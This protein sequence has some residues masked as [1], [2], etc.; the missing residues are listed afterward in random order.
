METL[1]SLSVEDFRCSTCKFSIP[2]ISLKEITLE[3]K[4]IGQERKCIS[5][6]DLIKN[7]EYYIYPN[8]D[9]TCINQRYQPK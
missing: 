2:I 3:P 8:E 6:F 5:F 7:D 1:K 9:D 4:I